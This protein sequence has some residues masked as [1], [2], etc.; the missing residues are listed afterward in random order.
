VTITSGTRLSHYE[1]IAPIGVGGMGE[2]YRARD[3]KLN[4]DVAIKVL[5]EAFARDSDRLAR[6]Q[7][8]AQVLA[9]LNHPNIAAI[10]GL[11]ESDSIRALVM[12]LVEGPTLDDRLSNGPIPV[13]EALAIAR[14]IAEALEVAHERGIVHRDLKP[15]NVKVTGDDKVKVLD[16]GLAK[17]LSDESEITDLSNSPTMIKGT[18]AGMILGTAAYMSPEQARGRAVDKRSDIWAFGVVLMEM[19]TG[20]RLFGGETV[21]D[22]MAAVL[23]Q[24]IDWT[25]L[26]ETTPTPIRR[27]LRRCLEKD[28]KNRLGDATSAKLEIDDALSYASDDRTLATL[29]PS[30]HSW[31]RTLLRVVLP[32]VLLTGLV[33]GFSVWIIQRG[34]PTPS[35]ELT[36]TIVPPSGVQ[37]LPVGTMGSPPHIS[38]D[39]SA[40]MFE[41]AHKLYLRRLNSLDFVEVPGSIPTSNESFWHGSGAITAPSAARDLV[42]VRLPDGAPEKLISLDGY[43]RGGSWSDKGTLLVSA[44]SHLLTRKPDGTASSISIPDKRTGNLVYPEFLSGSEDFLVL[45]CPEDGD[46]EVWLATMSQG[47]ITNHSVLFKNDTAARYT[48][49]DGGHVLFVKNDNLYSQRM[50]R[51]SRSVEGQPELDVKGVA[52]QPGLMRADFSV[53]LDGTIAWRPGH[54]ALAQV[55]VFDRKGTV[56]GTA[57]PPGAIESVFVSPTDDSRLLVI[58]EDAELVEVGQSSRLAF[59]RDTDWVSWSPDGKRVIGVQGGNRLVVR[60]A[61]NIGATDEIGQLPKGSWNLKAFSPDAKVALARIPPSGGA[62][63]IRVAEAASSSWTPLVGGDESDAD[64][65]FSPDGLFILYDTFPSSGIYVQPFPGPGKRQ[66]ISERGGDP[67]WRGDGKEIFF[68]RDEAVWSVKVTGAADSPAFSAPEK[69]FAGVRR[70]PTAVFQSQGLSVSHDGSRFFIVQGVEQPDTNVIH[71]MTPAKSSR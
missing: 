11:E 17:V 1:I 7:R 44:M 40:V 39:G 36:L 30:E 4:R 15:A 50:N 37:F 53:A 63:W 41:A 62:G 28:R 38:P 16:F 24:Q 9:S 8:E 65:G 58:D 3:S 13:D 43:T 61:D 55:T 27:L 12:E 32:A 51:S 20:K 68:V 59:P 69:L 31:R 42:E 22:V 21:S 48:P 45:F 6:F 33:V 49:W 70:A 60:P 71:V 64:L 54:A 19:L 14:Q 2:V 67:V 25:A 66:L 29:P 18:A 23:T 34:R 56:L 5:P 46:C 57:G 52:S 35:R 47:V 10:Y 26:P